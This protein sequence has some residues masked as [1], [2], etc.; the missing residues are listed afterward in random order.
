MGVLMIWA[1]Y[2]EA[3]CLRSSEG[4]IGLVASSCFGDIAQIN[5]K[6]PRPASNVGSIIWQARRNSKMKASTI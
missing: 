3:S 4:S 6:T 2:P 5:G 1:G